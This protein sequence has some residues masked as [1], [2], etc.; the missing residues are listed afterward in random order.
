MATSTAS[1]DA[2]AV[3]PALCQRDSSRSSSAEQQQ[4]LHTARCAVAA[5]ILS[6]QKSCDVFKHNNRVHYIFINTRFTHE[7]DVLQQLHTDNTAAHSQSHCL[8]TPESVFNMFSPCTLELYAI[9]TQHILPVN[10]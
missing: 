6:H 10:P 9:G 8:H 5:T 3:Q 4:L 1:G 7:E 2:V